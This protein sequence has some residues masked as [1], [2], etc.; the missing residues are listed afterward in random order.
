MFIDEIKKTL[1]E[2]Y[3][4]N[5]KKDQFSAETSSHWRDYG[6]KTQVNLTDNDFEIKSVGISSFREKTFL[7]L[8]RNIPIDYL[9][10]RLLIRYSAQPK[11]VK[12]AKE[13]ADKHG[14]LFNYDYAKHVLFF[15]LLTSLNRLE[16]N[17][18][19]CIIGDGHG[20]FGTLIKS[21]IPNAK[22]IFV[23]LGKSID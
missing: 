18:F 16:T 14:I 3:Y 22:I 6:R 11:T 23:N 1:Y 2:D 8:L 20:F 12:A 13:I 21:L 15:D 9:P 19:I 5:N 17:D 10:T 7:G 4:G